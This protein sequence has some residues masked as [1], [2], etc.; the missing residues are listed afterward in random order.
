[1]IKVAREELALAVDLLSR[2]QSK[3]ASEMP[4]YKAVVFESGD[5]VLC[6]TLNSTLRA[7]RVSDIPYSLD[8]EF[9]QTTWAME[10]DS[11]GHIVRTSSVDNIMMG[12]DER[13]G[14]W[15]V[16]SGAKFKVANVA[17]E[18]FGGYPQ[19]DYSATPIDV[20]DFLGAM[21]I[22]SNFVGTDQTRPQLTGVCIKGRTVYSSDSFCGVRL[23][24]ARKMGDQVLNFN[25]SLF[26]GVL[27]SASDKSEVLLGLSPD[28]SWIG[29]K[30]SF[31][32]LAVVGLTG[33]YPVQAMESIFSRVKTSNKFEL[34]INRL[35]M[36]KALHRAAYFIDKS[37]AFQMKLVGSNV[38]ISVTSTE[39]EHF[40]ELIPC[41]W[42]GPEG[43]VCSLS[44]GH[45]A[46]VSAM[47]KEEV[48]RVWFG[49]D[50]R[51]FWYAQG[52]GEDNREVSVWGMP[53]AVI[54]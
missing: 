15:D 36:D 10:T 54:Q 32:E 11:L 44:M 30:K 18:D 46:K 34:E 33:G 6:A 45:F 27:G 29:M 51:A 48:I 12:L 28:S 7:V 40:E 38:R 53:L 3:W 22:A 25:P 37:G 21:R 31:V 17:V 19:I 5:R 49:K 35:D 20:V 14:Q 2:G 42:T 9:P 16:R 52:M 26:T 41:N 13:S 23:Q 24:M 4:I 47:V 39:G 43:Y 1:M 8:G 50:P